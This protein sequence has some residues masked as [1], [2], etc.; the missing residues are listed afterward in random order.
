MLLSEYRINEFIDELASKSPAPGGGS[1]S[2]LAGAIGTALVSMVANLSYGKE[3]FMDKEALLSEILEEAEKIK[4][5]LILLIDKDTEAFNQ[6][7]NATKM[8][9]TT[10]EEKK[11]RSE[12][13]E[14]ALKKAT[15]IPLSIMEESLKA[16]KL[17]EK[18]LG[19]TTVNA[20]SDLGVGVLYLRTALYGGW[21]NVKI[22]L[23]SI[24]DEEFVK[25]VEKK[26][27]AILDQGI[28]LADVL[29]QRVEEE[30]VKK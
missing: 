3:K 20:I 11:L 27:R 2:A 14:R 23:N 28:R 1:A 4:S 19:N 24:K 13:I 16:L 25:D 6:V 9:R 21:L 22:N 5:S 18:A 8:P 17:H 10:E 26:A 7:A 15:L 29:Y 12:A 30:F